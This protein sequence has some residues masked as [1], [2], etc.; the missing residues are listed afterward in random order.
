MSEAHSYQRFFAELK[1]RRVFRV[2]A[3][4]GATAFVVLQVADLFQEGLELPQ[5]FLRV[6]T[7][8][9]LLGFPVALVVAWV[10][11]R[12]PA[13]V[14][15]TDPAQSGE[16]EEIVAS[17]PAKRWPMGLAAA[18]G[19]ALLLVGGW[20]GMGS[21]AAPGGGA[22]PGDGRAAGE[23]TSVGYSSIAVLPF[24]NMSGDPA[25]EYFSDG[26]SEELLNVLAQIEGL[27]VAARTSS[28]A[29][30][31]RELDIRE[32]GET[33]GVETILEG[34][35]RRGADGLRITA[36]LI[37]VGDGFHVWSETYDRG[38][39]D[40]LILQD[41]IAGS[42]AAALRPQLRGELVSV[43]AR[44][45]TA[46]VGAHDLYLRGRARLNARRSAEDLRA[47]ADDFRRAT[48]IDSTYARAWAGQAVATSL[49]AAYAGVPCSELAGS[50]IRL[51]DRALALD[52]EIA[53]AYAARY[54]IADCEHRW[55]DAE[56]ELLKAVAADPSY[57][58]AHQ[59]LGELYIVLGRS[60]EAGQALQRALRLDPASRPLAFAMHA[61]FSYIG[62]YDRALAEL[63][64]ARRLAADETGAG[65]AG[66]SYWSEFDIHLKRG[67]YD[68]ARAALASY[69]E[70]QGYD[71]ADAV[72]L[73]DGVE[74]PAR[75]DVAHAILV[76][77]DREGNLPPRDLAL[78]YALLGDVDAT[79]KQLEIAERAGDPFLT[80]DMTRGSYAP[81]ESDLRFQA[82]WERLNLPR[83]DDPPHG[84]Q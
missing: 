17:P 57:A 38:S 31:G 68:A 32:I 1:R 44:G 3:M 37:D 28:F 40:V 29:F 23:R 71:P 72:A 61:Y 25:D 70:S 7:V 60:D 30:K 50:V 78:W 80:H 62:E 47:A 2:A 9:S 14:R 5:V 35:V 21:P 15:R 39:E 65:S 13:G 84:A 33:L 16:I 12:T 22:A 48:E 26:L 81:V 20:W 6:V 41:E 66:S 49:L 82:M 42:V 56:T 55:T 27:K 67:D 58:T 51:A 11:E 10:Y 45:G 36:Q 59:W 69:A 75:R 4:Y 19:T 76:R 52:P 73:V 46:D 34:S 24:V 63:E 74:D 79:F 77:W 18:A 64:R 54:I 43:Q 8:L 83:R 53:G